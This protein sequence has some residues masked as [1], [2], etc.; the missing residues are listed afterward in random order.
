MHLPLWCAFEIPHGLAANAY[1]WTLAQRLV[2]GSATMRKLV[3]YLV[4]PAGVTLA[5]ILA[6]FSGVSWLQA[7]VSPRI[8]GMHPDSSR[9]FG[10][11]ENLQNLYLLGIV[12]V[13]AWAVKRKTLRIEKAAFAGLEARVGGLEEGLAALA[14]R[15]DTCEAM[16]GNHTKIL[17]DHEERITA[18]EEE[19]LGSLQRR[20][21]ALEQSLQALQVKI[22]NNRAKIEGVEGTLS[23]F[24]EEIDG[25]K[26]SMDDLQAQVAEQVEA[27]LAAV[28]QDL[29]AVKANQESQWVAIFLVPWLF[30]RLGLAGRRAGKEV[31]PQA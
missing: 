4:V 21:L 9:E 11:L 20:V 27:Q 8:A 7:L 15:M 29:D 14:K 13:A 24:Q 31:T 2:Y 12:V 1:G 3:I 22:D 10:L 25:V 6:Y 19:D 26:A 23:G 16:L 30:V 18:L 28:R 5:L 17:N